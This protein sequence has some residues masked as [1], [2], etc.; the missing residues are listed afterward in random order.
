MNWKDVEDIA[1]SDMAYVFDC[2]ESDIILAKAILELKKI[3]EDRK[4]L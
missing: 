1:D 4:N 2:T 3:L